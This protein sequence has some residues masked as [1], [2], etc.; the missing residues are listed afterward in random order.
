[1]DMKKVDSSQIAEIGHD[2]DTNTLAIRFKGV[3]GPGG[4]YHYPNVTAE[5]FKAFSAAKSLG[6]HFHT[7]IKG[8]KDHPHKKIDESK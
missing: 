3:G 1:M 7:H 2:P 5:K 4:L 6:K 8:H